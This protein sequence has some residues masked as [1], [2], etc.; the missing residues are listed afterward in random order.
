MTEDSTGETL[1]DLHGD[2]QRRDPATKAAVQTT[3]GPIPELHELPRA[4][5][6]GAYP[7]DSTG[8]GRRLGADVGYALEN[9]TKPHY[10]AATRQ[11]RRFAA[12]HAAPRARPPVDRR[13]RL[14]RTRG[15]R[16]GSARAGRPSSRSTGL[17]R[18]RPSTPT[19]ARTSSTTSTRRRRRSRVGRSR[20]PCWTAIPPTCSPASRSTTR[21]AA[22]LEG[23]RQILGSDRGVLPLRGEARST[24]TATRRSRPAQFIRQAK[25][26]SRLEG[27]EPAAA[28]ALL[29][30]VAV[31]RDQADADAGRLRV[32]PTGRC[33]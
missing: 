23:Y 33:R 31:R 20:P 21:P 17:R 27:A 4:T 7:F 1:A 8:G 18:E 14:P 5:S 3:V 2:R 29:P 11:R 16:S 10:A 26:H 13:Q 12:Q 25:Q 22:M 32:S 30:A 24:A 6:S 9:Q 15:T 19:P 28:R